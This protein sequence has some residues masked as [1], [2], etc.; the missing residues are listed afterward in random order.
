LTA[1]SIA[2]SCDNNGQYGPSQGRDDDGYAKRSIQFDLQK[3]GVC[4]NYTP[5]FHA[6]IALE[7]CT[8]A[9]KLKI[10]VLATGLARIGDGRCSAGLVHSSAPNSASTSQLGSCVAT[11]PVLKTIS[12][13]VAGLTHEFSTDRKHRL[14]A[15]DRA[16]VVDKVQ[17][18][19]DWFHRLTKFLR[20]T[21]YLFGHHVTPTQGG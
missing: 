19:C 14:S 18:G 4:L 3:E 15:A 11:V 13:V 12:D 20:N 2:D 6:R 10:P 16:G 21:A 8:V 7:A 5:T 17:L 1:T 9:H